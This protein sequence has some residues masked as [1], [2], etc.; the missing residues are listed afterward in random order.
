MTL[1][2][3]A[4]VRNS[5]HTLVRRPSGGGR[6]ILCRCSPTS[7]SAQQL[8]LFPCKCNSNSSCTGQV[9]QLV[10]S[11]TG[12]SPRGLLQAQTTSFRVSSTHL[13]R[14]A[15]VAQMLLPQAVR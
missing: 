3:R 4:R 14:W 13:D 6:T 10:H 15:P 11:R 12:S 9:E 5:R 2:M 7:C 1:S 8:G